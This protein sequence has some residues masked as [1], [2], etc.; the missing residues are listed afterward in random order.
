MEKNDFNK[1]RVLARA[2]KQRQTLQWLTSP[3]VVGVAFGRKI[4]HNKTTE[5]PSVIVYVMK[6]VN[7]AFLPISQLLPQKLFVGGDCLRVDVVETGPLY[8]LSF[9]ARE[10][11]A[12]SGIS[13]GHFN[14]TAGTLGCLVNDLTDGS[15]CILSNNHVLADEN[16]ASIGDNIIQPGA[17]DGGVVPGDV[18][19]TLKRFQM[20]NATGNTI[21]AAIA[22][23]SKGG[24]V[25]NQM[26]DNLM[27]VPSPDHPAVG[28]LFAGSCN[29]TILNPIDAVLA[30]LNIEFLN[31]PGA[32][33]GADIGMAVEKVG[34]T[35]EYTTADV[36]EIDATVSIGYDFGT[37]TFDGQIT[38]AWMSDGGDSGSVVCRGGNGGNIGDEKCGCGSSSA[39][40]GILQ[41]DIKSDVAAE[42]LFRSHVSNT[43]TGRFLLDTYFNNEEHILGRINKIKNNKEETSYLQYLYDKYAEGLRS[44][45]INPNS[46]QRIS[47]EQLKEAREVLNRFMRHLNKNEQE[48]AEHLFKLA[49]NFEGKTVK[50]ALDM[51]ND[52]KLYNDVVK[53]VSGVESLKKKDC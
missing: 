38:T 28:L 4:V 8:P 14:I 21:D 27:P 15:L 30:T 23:V 36:L 20:I 40:A 32:T 52:K 34:R 16:A 17:Y 3:N 44:M 49:E 10:R 19:A 13:I 53:T 47:S 22:Q 33:V 48:A 2:A 50:E 5:E 24:D 18:I 35:T 51:L 45:A 41:R 29:R 26:K 11:P 12:P 25:I 46:D 6:K 37:A 7:K 39:A 42:K 1:Y 9:T 43:L 31:G